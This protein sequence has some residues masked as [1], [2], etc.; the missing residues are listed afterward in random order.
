MMQHSDTLQNVQLEQSWLTIGTFDGVHLGHQAIIKQM[1]AAAHQSGAPA[2]VLTFHPHPAVVLGR[3][4][5][6]F[7]L[8]HPTERAIYFAELGVD[9]VI[10]HPF[11][12]QV[13]SLT[14][15]EFISQIKKNLG[16]RQL[17]VGHDF[18]LGRN[19]EGNIP[20]LESLSVEFGYHL[21][22]ID[23]ITAEATP[24]SSS[25][26][27]TLLRDGDVEQARKLLGRPYHVQGMV[28]PGDGRGR[29]IGI[30]TANIDVW[31]EKLLPKPGVYVC[32]VKRGD[33]L[34]PAVSNIG[35]RP[36]FENTPPESRLEV[37]VLD[38]NQD[39][40]GQDLELDFC[41]R[42]RDEMRF[43]NAAALIEQI[44]RDIQSTRLYFEN[45][46]AVSN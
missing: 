40:Y 35:F 15:Q 18:A 25:H 29:T 38:M 27:R 14:A 23:E 36:T 12:R 39:F 45:Q 2:V 5:G 46:P 16:L 44:H 43:P 6:P 19:R 37:H 30:P 11:D 7:Y 20:K 1:V 26:I 21:H 24:V 9:L 8:T 41:V 33:E 3:R 10:T 31:K 42:L 32:R 28:I 17:W 34:W 13:A 4:A 22:I